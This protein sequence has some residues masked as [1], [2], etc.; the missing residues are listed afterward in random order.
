MDPYK[1]LGVSRKASDDDIKK[2]YRT[3]ARKYH[4]DKY[5]GDPHAEE[6]GIRMR[7]I[8]EAYDTIVKERKN[9]SKRVDFKEKFNERKKCRAEKKQK[10]NRTPIRNEANIPIYNRVKQAMKQ[11]NISMAAALL[12]RVPEKD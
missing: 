1:E 10:K 8:N 6:A 7:N 11:E 4:P 9:P 5:V 12:Q 2:A 3:L